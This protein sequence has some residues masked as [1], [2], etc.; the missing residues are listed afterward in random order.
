MNKIERAIAD[1]KSNIE[2]LRKDR[3]ILEAEIETY[4]KQLAA[5]E[6]IERN[7]SIP[8]SNPQVKVDNESILKARWETWDIVKTDVPGEFYDVE[9]AYTD[10]FTKGSSEEYFNETI[11][12][13]NKGVEI[14]QGGFCT[15]N[16]GNN[17]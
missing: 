8:H 3:M 13:G 2:G 14:V 16:K 15:T 1:T 9:S 5:L 12:G 11:L 17:E 7:K 10:G 6:S 4:E